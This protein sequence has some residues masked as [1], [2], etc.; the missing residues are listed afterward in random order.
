MWIDDNAIQDEGA[1]VL[2]EVVKAHKSLTRF[3]MGIL[4][5]HKMW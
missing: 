4:R 1:I 2:A 5:V 3:S